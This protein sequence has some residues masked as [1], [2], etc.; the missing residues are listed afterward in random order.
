MTTNLCHCGRPS[1]D[2]F[3]CQPCTDTLERAL[4]DLP[5][6]MSELE[7]TVTRQAK[8]ASGG[9]KR[10]KTDGPLPFDWNASDLAWAASNTLAVW[11][12]TIAESRGVELELLPRVPAGPIHA[13][14]GDTSCDLIRRIRLAHATQGQ[15]LLVSRWLIRNMES[16]R[17]DEAAAVL[18]DEITSIIPAIE[19][20]T[21][22]DEERWYAGPCHATVPNIELHDDGTVVYLGGETRCESQVFVA[23]LQGK[24]KCDGWGY[25]N[26]PGCGTVHNPDERQEW[27][28]AHVQ[29]ALL[30]LDE[31]LPALPALTGLAP[32]RNTVQTWARRKRLLA[33]SVNRYGVE[34]FR[35]A[36]VLT[37]VRDEERRPG[38]RRKANTIG[39][40]GE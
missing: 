6:W 36:D 4:G 8:L 20:A 18:F 39:R 11:A 5:S 33:R 35:G 24:I 9:G 30:T 12:R 1:P 16:V 15:D 21:D 7:I 26:L 32:L 3:L 34:M 31:L 23:G 29:E 2:A 13:V 40:I 25:L 17:Q 19:A 10:S 28:L 27:L 37:L 22:R 38:P 14:C